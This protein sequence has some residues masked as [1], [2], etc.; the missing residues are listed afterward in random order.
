M[1]CPG[2]GAASTP[3]F[4][5]CKRC[6]G[7]LTETVQLND[8]VMPPARNTLAAF[9]LAVA[10]VAITLGGLGI[11]FTNSMEL[12]RPA[13][14]GFSAPMHDA[15]ITASMMVMFGTATIAIVVFLLAKLFARV[16][17][18]A[19][20]G[21]NSAQSKK[22]VTSIYQPAQMSAPQLSAPPAAVSSVTEHTT[23]TFRPP[24]YD[25]VNRRE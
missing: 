2:C 18:L 6:G 21:N 14:P 13:P 19:P 1:Y 10:T 9:F 4:K 20:A 8:P 25:E 5:Y 22:P 12:V 3:G 15:A 7:N 16:M 11:V 24:V 23:R 17:G